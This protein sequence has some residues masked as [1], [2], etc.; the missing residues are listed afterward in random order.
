MMSLLRKLI[1]LISFP[2]L[3]GSCATICG[4]SQYHAHILVPKHPAAEVFYHGQLMGNGSAFIVVK[5]S[6]ANRFSIIVREKGCEEQRFSYTKKAF[7][8]WALAGSLVTW[9][10][11]G[12]LIDFIDGAL[13]KPSVKEPGI[14]KSDDK[15]FQY[16]LSYTGC[17]STTEEV[18]SPIQD[19]LVDVVYLKNG[20]IIRGT[21]IDQDP[22]KFVK[23]Q[24]LDGSVFVF[25]IDEIEKVT[26]E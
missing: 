5:R 20:S 23:I 2:L 25:K 9:G 18:V 19:K 7:R 17:R 16:I 21:L 4:G 8:G 12:A 10:Q 26:R 3:L 14:M 24:A 15:N 13:W 11:V 6:Q 22:T 1:A